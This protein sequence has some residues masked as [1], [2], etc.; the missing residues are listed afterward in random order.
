MMEFIASLIKSGAEQFK[1]TTLNFGHIIMTI[2]FKLPLMVAQL[3]RMHTELPIGDF[4]SYEVLPYALKTVDFQLRQGIT[5][6]G[7]VKAF[8]VNISTQAMLG[9]VI[10]HTQAGTDK[11]GWFAKL[12]KESI[13]A[14][15]MVAHEKATIPKMN[16]MSD[17][18]QFFKANDEDSAHYLYEQMGTAVVMSIMTIV[19]FS[20]TVPIAVIMMSMT[21]VSKAIQILHKINASIKN[22][23][24]TI[25]RILIDTMYTEELEKKKKSNDYKGNN[26][27]DNLHKIMKKSKNSEGSFFIFDWANKKALGFSAI[28]LNFLARF[29]MESAEVLNMSGNTLLDSDEV[30]ERMFNDL[31]GP[32]SNGVLDVI[33]GSSEQMMSTM[34]HMAIATYAKHYGAFTLN[35]GFKKQMKIFIDTQGQQKLVVADHAADR[36]KLAE[37]EREKKEQER[38]EKERVEKERLEKEL[39]EREKQEREK[40]Q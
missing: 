3:E 12:Y 5:L 24:G 31:A 2:L 15:A 6:M 37:S 4:M 38:L 18:I 32:S 30:G 10:E 17:Y 26:E 11:D 16:S 29:V 21:H 28:I 34:L 1:K 8:G 23:Y 22:D 19:G 27:F 25:T 40:E 35:A 9:N 14:A 39:E 36:A 33:F 7:I 20:V 13:A